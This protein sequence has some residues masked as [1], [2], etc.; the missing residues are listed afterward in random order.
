MDKK[1]F[2]QKVAFAKVVWS[3]YNIHACRCCTYLVRRDKCCMLWFVGKDIRHDKEIFCLA[4]WIRGAQISG[5][6]ETL[7]TLKNHTTE[8]H[9]SWNLDTP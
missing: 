6:Y 9:A 2:A 1:W 7:Y 5:P 3:A 4:L 8:E